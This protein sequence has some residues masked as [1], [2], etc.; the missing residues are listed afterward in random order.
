MSMLIIVGG[1]LASGKSTFA[2]RLSEE[3]GIPYYDKDTMNEVIGKQIA[4]YSIEDRKRLSVASFEALMHIAEREL[5]SG[6]TLILESNFKKG[7]EQRVIEAAEKFDAEVLTYIFTCDMKVSYERFM[8]REV[9]LER[10]PIHKFHG[11]NDF[12]AFSSATASLAEFDIGGE[13]KEIDTTDFSKTDYVEI[14]KELKRRAE[15]Q[16]ERL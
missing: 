9:S 4:L 10:H 13:R 1:L 7:E 14:I 2:K 5:A 16:K 12:A 11:L 15:M 3:L 8:A 6:N